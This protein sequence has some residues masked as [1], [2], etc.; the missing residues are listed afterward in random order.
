VSEEGI[1]QQGFRVSGR[2]QGV[3]FRVWTRGVAEELGLRGTVRNRIDGSV[4]THVVGS[5]EAVRAFESR[6][7]EGPAAAAVEGVEVLESSEQLPAGP[8]QILATG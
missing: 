8:F 4:E 1:E 3:Y 5:S 2:V 7:W 6:L